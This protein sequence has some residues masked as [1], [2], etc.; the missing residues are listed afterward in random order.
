MHGTSILTL[1]D[2][3]FSV[4][5]YTSIRKEVVVYGRWY[6]KSKGQFNEKSK[7]CYHPPLNR[8]EIAYLQ[9]TKFSDFSRVFVFFFFDQSSLNY[10]VLACISFLILSRSPFHLIQEHISISLSS[11]SFLIFALAQ[12]IQLN[13]SSRWKEEAYKGSK[14]Y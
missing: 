14:K 10:M 12:G 8:S 7:F 3:S 6:R 13:P 2:G 4:V 9:H 5:T 11:K 1:M